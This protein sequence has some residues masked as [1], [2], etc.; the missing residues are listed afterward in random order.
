MY[1]DDTIIVSDKLYIPSH[2]V[3]DKRVRR[4][5]ILSFYQERACARCDYKPDRPSD[6]CMQCDAYNGT[7]KLASREIKNNIEYFGIPLGD[8]EN[9][10][11]KL[12]ID[13][14]DFEIV[15]KRTRAPFDYS[16]RFSKAK[17]ADHNFMWRDEQLKTV[18]DMVKAKYGVFVMPPR[19]GKSLT[20]LN[21]GIT[22]GHKFLIVA[23]QYD[24]LKQFI[25][26]IEKFTNLPELQ[27]K[28]GKKLYGF[29]KT[30]ADLKDIQIGIITYQSLINE[31]GRR[32]LRKVNK[33][34]GSVFVDEIHSAAA[35]VYTR[36]LNSMK[37]RYRMGCT[38]TFV[39]KDNKQLLVEMVVGGVKSE[40]TTA[41]LKAKL[42]V[43]LTGVKT[44]RKFSGRAGFTYCGKFLAEDDKRN[45]LIVEWVMKDLE[46]GHSIVI[47]TYFTEHVST[48]VKLI[49][50]AA[51]YEVAAP[52]V[53]GGTKKNKE[54]RDKVK[55]RA[56]D[57]D[58]RVVVGI[59]RLLQRGIN[60]PAWSCLYHIQPINNAPNWKQETS[61]ILT[62]DPNKRTP[63]I[64]FFLDEGV[65]YSLGMFAQTWQQSLKF[66]HTPTEAARERVKEALK[67][68]K[69]RGDYEEYSDAPDVTEKAVRTVP[70]QPGGLF[71]RMKVG[72]RK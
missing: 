26:D 15:D 5:Y 11:E 2:M 23:D 49:N 61:R 18:K 60:V 63:I 66:K 59:R 24:F 40:Q 42:M 71:A 12:N 56:I 27:E 10:E 72:K 13:F 62:P 41:Q 44:R 8:R 4:N 19:S 55:Q 9:I 21:I 3:N 37:M 69:S 14:D 64:R 53:G 68:H 50:N 47:P 6:A 17:M 33:T 54:Y 65:N 52:F 16:V 28:T 51:G 1:S 35:K 57:R 32:L 38:G 20:L 39:R 67:N 31:N 43:I 22:L 34:F 25:G 30:A 29:V 36:L 58:I 7:Y 48:L 45:K 46:A 70:T